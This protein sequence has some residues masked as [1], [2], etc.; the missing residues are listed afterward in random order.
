M[1]KSDSNDKQKNYTKFFRTGIIIVIVGI[2]I[3]WSAFLITSIVIAFTGLI[4]IL[5]GKAIVHY[6]AL[7]KK[8]PKINSI[9]LILIFI[10][11]MMI[12]LPIAIDKFLI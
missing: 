7:K 12:L 9:V 10:V 5:S 11:L 8:D 1:L 3:Y 2:L 4:V 6:V